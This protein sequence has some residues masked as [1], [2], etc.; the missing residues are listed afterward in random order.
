MEERKGKPREEYLPTLDAVDVLTIACRSD[1][2]PVKD[3]KE[4]EFT[5]QGHYCGAN[6]ICSA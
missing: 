2:V 3:V 1:P 6:G 5:D 4:T